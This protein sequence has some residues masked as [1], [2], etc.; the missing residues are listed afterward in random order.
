MTSALQVEADAL[1]RSGRAA[2]AERAFARL[3]EQEPDNPQALN[4]LCAAALRDRRAPL[5]LDY[6]TRAARAVPTDA[7]SRFHLGR[8]CEAAGDDAAAIEAYGEAVR[9]RPDFYVARLH[10]GL[11]LRRSPAAATGTRTG[12]TGNHAAT[13]ASTVQLARALQDAQ[14][15]QKWVDAASTPPAYRPPVEEAVRA[16]RSARGAALGALI[17]PLEAQYGRSE[18]A[19]VRDCIAI[20]MQER[21][22]V[23][24]DPRQRPTFLLFPGLPTTPYLE[25]SLFAWLPELEAHTPQI[26][27]ELLQLLPRTQGRE[28]VFTQ[29]SVESQNL[30]GT[31]G[32]PSWN[33]Y[34][35]F[36]H[37]VRRDD[38][39]AQ[40]PVTAASLDAL[41]LAHV[42]EHGPEV[43]FSVF[44]PG[45]HLLPHRGVTNT[46]LVG[47]LPLI[48]PP[49][50][51][52]VVGGE[53]HA[54][55]EG[56]VVVFDDTY[57]H[58]A[59]N[60]SDSVRVVMIFDLWNPHLTEAERAAVTDL[61]GAI[62]DFRHLVE[63][64]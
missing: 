9:L 13:L 14:A 34:Y 40:C 15:R 26:R 23:Y 50:C 55:Q 28:R 5:A 3:L 62:G 8:A 31:R 12:T 11:A 30:R 37:G 1:L 33:G 27:A 45:T 54:W 36:R 16:V 10:L 46:R 42:R 2:E 7:T 22:P 47:H 21:A 19:R 32:A 53:E 59:W 52:L 4:V 35:F 58:E 63:A 48:V 61:V 6:A 24:P 38:N 56:R 41:P 20:F 29:E 44:T 49:D 25:R 17:A 39:C 18:L 43:L 51:A 57:E 64:G 60:R